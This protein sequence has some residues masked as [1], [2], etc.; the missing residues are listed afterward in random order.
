MQTESERQGNRLQLE[1][2]GFDKSFQ[3]LV[4][5]ARINTDRLSRHLAGDNAGVLLKCGLGEGLNY[6][7]SRLSSLSDLRVRLSVLCV[8]KYF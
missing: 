3:V 8:R 7:K 5:F 2:V 1:I 4:P 6:H